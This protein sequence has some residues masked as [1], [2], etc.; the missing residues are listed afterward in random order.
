VCCLEGD[1]DAAPG[2]DCVP[3]AQHSQSRRS[4]L[5]LP[6]VERRPVVHARAPARPRSEDHPAALLR[7]LRHQLPAVQRVG[8]VVPARHA[9]AGVVHGAPDDAVGAPGPASRPLVVAARR[10]RRRARHRRRAAVAVASAAR[11]VQLRRTVRRRSA[12][13]AVRLAVTALGSRL[14]GRGSNSRPPRQI[15]GWVTFFGRAIHL[16]HPRQLS[17]LPSAEREMS[18]DQSA[19]TLCGWGVKEGMVHSTCGCTCGWQVKLPV[20]IFRRT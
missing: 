18:T 7:Q 15:P 20:F 9:P 10:R 13:A 8:P 2:V 1:E 6:A 16:S 3:A 11:P 5:R 14:D 4:R 12:R 17:L 19:V